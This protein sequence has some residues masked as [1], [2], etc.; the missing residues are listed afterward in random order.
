MLRLSNRYTT[1]FGCRDLVERDT[2]PLGH[3]SCKQS[4][5]QQEQVEQVLKFQDVIE[6]FKPNLNYGEVLKISG[7][8]A[9]SAHASTKK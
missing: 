4:K 7:R 2:R 5:N 1:S 3:S 8:A 6:G 9:G